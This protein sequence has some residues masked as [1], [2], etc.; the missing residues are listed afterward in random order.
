MN[1]ERYAGKPL[2]R[3]LELYTLWSINHLSA[4]NQQTLELMSPKLNKT[5]GGDGSWQSAIE[6]AMELPANMPQLI[7]DLWQ[8][9]LGISE[10]HGVELS[11]QQFAEMFV[12]SNLAG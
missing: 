1:T 10:E 2:L 6:A 12:D 4:E 9:N 8:K 3:L 11:P 7:R 5:F